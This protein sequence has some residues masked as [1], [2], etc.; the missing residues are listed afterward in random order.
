MRSR[1]WVAE[2]FADELT[3]QFLDDA[4]DILCT[5]LPRK[6]RQAT[7][8][9]F[10][11]C[12]ILRNASA[13]IGARGIYDMCLAWS[14]IAPETLAV[15]SETE[16]KKLREECGRVCAALRERLLARKG[17]AGQSMNADDRLP[18]HPVHMA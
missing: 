2:E 15:L 18:V 4:S 11:S 6:W 8:R 17:A 16:L 3:A 10:G 5:T 14:Q 13:N 12:Y 9:H 1:A 7:Y